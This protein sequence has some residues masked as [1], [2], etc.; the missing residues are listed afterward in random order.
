M[1]RCP[2]CRRDYVDDTLLYCLEDGAALVQ[3]SVASSG[4]PQTATL[5]GG[6]A[7]T[8]PQILTTDQ[9]VILPGGMEA[10]PPVPFSGS[11]ERQSLS[12]QRTAEPQESRA[13]QMSRAA[14]P[15]IA[16]AVAAVVLVGGFFGYRYFN[17]ADTEQ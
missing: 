7:P 3:G 9:T 1:K 8:R 16:A 10:E 2:E 13:P 5:S 6:D 12:A 17:A 15:L 11:T 4:E 14:K